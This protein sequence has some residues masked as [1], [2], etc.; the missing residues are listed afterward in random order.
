MEAFSTMVILKK[1]P[2]FHLEKQ[3]FIWLTFNKQ[4]NN[5]K[6]IRCEA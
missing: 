1:L 3:N 6:L 4:M 2:E 5:F